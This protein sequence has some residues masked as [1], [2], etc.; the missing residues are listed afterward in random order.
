VLRFPKSPL[1]GDLPAVR[2]VGGVDVL[3]E[4]SD[5]AVDVLLIAVGATA[6]DVLAAC[7]SA[8]QAGYSVRVVDPRWVTPVD[9]AL[10]GLAIDASLVVTIEDGVVDGGA[11]SRIAQ[12]LRAAGIDV[13][14]R[15][16]GIPTE[17][18][19]H[20][21]LADVRSRLGLTPQHIGRRVVEWS[22]LVSRRAEDSHEA[23]AHAGRTT[24]A[25]TD[26][27]PSD[28]APTAPGTATSDLP[29]TTPGH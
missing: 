7:E 26:P 21:K 25:A 6:P 19:R 23:R 12:A 17:F 20:G 3:S 2:R 15:E 1:I 16:I 4:P 22:A 13:P 27:R 8:G 11:G 10:V 24:I 18:V 9:P 29:R 5:G 28:G 14:T